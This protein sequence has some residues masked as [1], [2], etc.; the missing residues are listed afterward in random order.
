MNI[1]LNIYFI[2][3]RYYS[4]DI[5]TCAE[6]EEILTAYKSIPKNEFKI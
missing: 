6:G 5:E 1:N 4:N 3:P 2:T